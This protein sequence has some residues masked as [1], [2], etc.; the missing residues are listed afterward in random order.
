MPH[1]RSK[2][3]QIPHLELRPQGY[4]WRRRLPRAVL[5]SNCIQGLCEGAVFRSIRIKPTPDHRI[6][7]ND[8]TVRSSPSERKKKM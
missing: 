6:L 7:R 2:H 8:T 5:E 3:A 4:V 1:A